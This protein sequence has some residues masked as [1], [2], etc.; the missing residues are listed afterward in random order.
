MSVESRL[1]LLVAGTVLMTV[2]ERL[3]GLMKYMLSLWMLFLV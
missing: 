2:A 1:K 3:S